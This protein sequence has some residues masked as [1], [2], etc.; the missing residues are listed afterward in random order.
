MTPEVHGNMGRLPFPFASGLLVLA[1][2]GGC[3]RSNG[4]VTIPVRGEVLYQGSPLKEGLVV[5]LPKNSDD[6]RQA[7]G[8]IEADGSFV[9][10][11]FKKGDGV[12]PGEYAI[13]VYPYDSPAGAERTREQIEAAA[14]TG[15]PRPATMIP[16][17]YSDPAASG[18]TDTIN[19]E[20]SGV[21]QIELTD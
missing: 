17:R 15:A 11:T 19:D 16:E 7:S 21:K 4:P 5:Y 13:V 6:S 10:T 8:K 20:H 9:L 14:Q 18:L 3:G 12:V 2:F 1:V